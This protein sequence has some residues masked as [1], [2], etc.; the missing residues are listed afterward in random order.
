MQIASDHI[1][2]V[3]PGW[4]DEARQAIYN[5]ALRCKLLII[6]DVHDQ[7]DAAGVGVPTIS[8]GCTLGAL[9]SEAKK[10][11]YIESTD[12]RRRSSR[13][14]SHADLRPVWRS[15]IFDPKAPL[16]PLV[17]REGPRLCHKCGA[18]RWV[19]D[20]ICKVCRAEQEVKTDD[21]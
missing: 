19:E 8:H 9:M 10:N 1:E 2:R 7:L 14:V 5:A 21:F 17:D 11:G 6:D 13:S 20:G 16:V 18:S 4:K 12:M 15:C 3:D